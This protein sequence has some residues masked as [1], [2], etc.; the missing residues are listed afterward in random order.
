MSVFVRTWLTVTHDRYKQVKIRSSGYENVMKE[1]VAVNAAFSSRPRALSRSVMGVTSTTARRRTAQSMAH[2]ELERGNTPMHG[3]GMSGDLL[4]LALYLLTI[5]AW[6]Y[7][8]LICVF[9]DRI[10]LRKRLGTHALL[11]CALGVPGL[12]T[13][14]VGGAFL[15]FGLEYILWSLMIV[16]LGVPIAGA[17]L[18]TREPHKQGPAR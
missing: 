1:A 15:L 8:W 5:V 10:P 9:S 4:H 12:A 3:Y 11:I 16:G 2:R 7:L 17:K 14:M 18:V 13:F 6:L